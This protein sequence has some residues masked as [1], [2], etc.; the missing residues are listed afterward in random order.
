MR[1][2]RCDRCGGPLA[3]SVRKL[4]TGVRHGQNWKTLEFVRYY[5]PECYRAVKR[6]VEA[7]E[8]EGR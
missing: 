7:C 4:W 2:E 8:R 3:G 5:C 1:V 6:A